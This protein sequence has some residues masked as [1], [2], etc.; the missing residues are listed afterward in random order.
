M[1][2][3]V[4]NRFSLRGVR[5]ALNEWVA[6]PQLAQR[7]PL[8]RG[9][10]LAFCAVAGVLVGWSLTVLTRPIDDE[11][12]VARLAALGPA[13]T[14]RAV[15]EQW[16]EMSRRARGVDGMRTLEALLPRAVYP[17]RPLRGGWF[18]R[19]N[20]RDAAT[21]SSLAGLEPA[22]TGRELRRIA[23]RNPD[24]VVAQYELARHH[25]QSEGSN[26]AVAY[27]VL[28]G[29]YT[30]RPALRRPSGDGPQTQVAADVMLR[31]L[32]GVVAT[33]AHHRE[34]GIGFLK[35]AI[36][37]SR[38][39][40][41]V[42]EDADPQAHRRREGVTARVVP[43]LEGEAAEI[44]PVAPDRDFS[45]L[46]LY[47]ALIVGYWRN[48]SWTDTPNER[49][50]EVARDVVP[51]GDLLGRLLQALV[52]PNLTAIRAVGTL[53][54]EHLRGR[55]HIIWTVS[56]LHRLRTMI[57]AQ[58]PA[59]HLAIEAAVLN[60]LATRNPSSEF[61]TP[62]LREA[63]MAQSRRSLLEAWSSW[64]SDS[65]QTRSDLVVPLLAWSSDLLG[66]PSATPPTDV[67]QDLVQETSQRLPRAASLEVVDK[68]SRE[69]R[70]RGRLDRTLRA[71][72]AVRGGEPVEGVDADTFATSEDKEWLETWYRSI[73]YG[74]AERLDREIESQMFEGNLDLEMFWTFLRAS[75]DSGQSS[76]AMLR[77]GLRE[78]TDVPFDLQAYAL[79]H[80]YERTR[81][82][83][84][85]ALSALAALAG[86]IVYIGISRFRVILHGR[87][88][89]D[90]LKWAGR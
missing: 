5:N 75:G 44:T 45:T 43:L 18:G 14:Q 39:L 89:R 32:T 55:E 71:I 29:L 70:A 8:E 59:R 66:D 81:L 86:W 52:V 12:F 1:P 84:I 78:G 20:E 90:E 31:F 64:D 33:H 13:D 85:V 3:R 82:A 83:V 58:A 68:W 51:T 27:A 79:I 72:L 19:L 40:H 11:R 6:V 47:D 74:Y 42:R 28:E 2:R 36:G 37:Q 10:I 54:N 87:F 46:A 49:A 69:L 57:P 17:M 21:L 15:V 35:D 24:S 53:P 65:P 88:Y 25:L 16:R 26:P 80:D 48:E 41:H 38:Y 50:R 4:R 22:E 61:L 67:V 60:E 73:A 23:Y 34:K 30:A 7:Y 76:M 62:E 56:N 77:S 63:A 9:I